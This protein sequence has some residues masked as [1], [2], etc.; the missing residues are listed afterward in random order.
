MLPI[1][2]ARSSSGML[3]IGRIAYRRQGVTGVQSAAEVKS[4]IALLRLY[5][6]DSYISCDIIVMHSQKTVPVCHMYTA[7]N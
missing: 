1:S 6:R 3:T 5:S 2:M 7:W 4:V